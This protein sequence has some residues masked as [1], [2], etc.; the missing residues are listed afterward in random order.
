[1]TNQLNFNM[2]FAKILRKK[3]QEKEAGNNFVLLPRSR[4]IIG[5]FMKTCLHT[6]IRISKFFKREAIEKSST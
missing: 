6:P 5:Q 4:N 1:M 3:K 2:Y